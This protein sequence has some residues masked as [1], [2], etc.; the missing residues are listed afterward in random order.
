MR[1]LMSWEKDRLICEGKRKKKAKVCAAND[2]MTSH[3]WACSN[4]FPY[5]PLP[6]T[7]EALS[8]AFIPDIICHYINAGQSVPGVQAVLSPSFL[9]TGGAEQEKEKALTLCTH[10]SAITRTAV[11]PTLFQSH[12]KSGMLRRK[13]SPS[14]P[15]SVCCQVYMKAQRTTFVS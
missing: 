10:C 13:L 2:L 4:G 8:S 12:P 7:K 6:K 9:P 11:L 15:D 3:T 5:P 1:K 14:Q